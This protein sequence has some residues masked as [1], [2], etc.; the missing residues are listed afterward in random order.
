MKK[1]G[2]EVVYYIFDWTCWAS[3]HFDSCALFSWYLNKSGWF[4]A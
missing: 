3:G 2:R 4:H 1:I